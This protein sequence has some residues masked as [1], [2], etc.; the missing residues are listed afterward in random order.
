MIK[1]IIL[2]LICSPIARGAQAKPQPI[3]RSQNTIAIKVYQA[4]GKR[5]RLVAG[6][7][8]TL[9]DLTDDVSGCLDVFDPHA[10]IAK[11]PLEIKVIDRVRKDD[12]DYLV[13]LTG[14]QSNCNV[15]GFCGA[16]VNLTLIWLKLGAG[17]KLEEKK[18]VVIE[19]CRFDIYIKDHDYDRLDYPQV[20]LVRGN[21]TVEYG[22]TLDDNDR[23]LSRLA[24]D[25][26][27][28]EQGFVIT[29]VEKTSKQ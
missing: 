24:Y 23:N 16:A 25:R 17:L 26:K 29:T 11:R 10:P 13:L 21:L 18:A 5:I 27:S 12:K 7:E 9:I 20:R 8:R 22:K 2:V 3:T 1:S 14:A 15:Q 6:K 19:D 4:R 28:P